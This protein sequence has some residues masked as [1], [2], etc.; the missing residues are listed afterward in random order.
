MS[1]E[2]HGAW[3]MLIR[4]VLVYNTGEG[5]KTVDLRKTRCVGKYFTGLQHVLFK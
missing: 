2:W 3:V 1:G 5:V 4:R